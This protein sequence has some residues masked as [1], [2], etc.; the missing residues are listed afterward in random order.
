MYA[1]TRVTTWAKFL[2]HSTR[3]PP[4]FAQSFRRPARSDDSVHPPG[5]KIAGIAFAQ[6]SRTSTQA[7]LTKPARSLTSALFS[8][9]QHS[10][11]ERDFLG[12]GAHTK[13]Y[14][15]KS[16]GR[17]VL[18]GSTRL[19][20]AGE[21]L[22][23]HFSYRPLIRNAGPSEMPPARPVMPATTAGHATCRLIRAESPRRGRFAGAVKFRWKAVSGESLPGI[24]DGRRGVPIGEGGH[25]RGGE[26]C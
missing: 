9:T 2:T 17:V 21:V 3:V 20:P 11:R 25:P 13:H 5:T 16:Y 12:R 6:A 8:P 10:K 19:S 24:S 7:L 15:D 1:R 4:P 26:I 22:S 14:Q 23:S 18:M